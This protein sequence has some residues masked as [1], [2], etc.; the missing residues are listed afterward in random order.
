MAVAMMLIVTTFGTANADIEVD[1]ITLV[2]LSSLPEQFPSDIRLS[3]NGRYVTLNVSNGVRDYV[4]IDLDT[5]VITDVAL[6]RTVPSEDGATVTGAVLGGDGTLM[7]E[8]LATGELEPAREA[9]DV[10]DGLQIDGFRLRVASAIDGFLLVSATTEDGS[11]SDT[12]LW[13][14]VRGEIAT[15][16]TFLPRD[17]NLVTGAQ[18]STL[19]GREVLQY[20]TYGVVGAIFSTREVIDLETLERTTI[21]MPAEH[22]PFL[23]TW[24]LSSNHEWIVFISEQ[25]DVV[26]GLDDTPRYYRLHR[27]SGDVEALPIDATGSDRSRIVILD[28]GKVIFDGPAPDR[29]T[30][31]LY[32]W[33]GGDSAEQLLRSVNGGTADQGLGSWVP[34]WQVTPSGRSIVFTSWASDLVAETGPEEFVLRLYRIGES[35]PVAPALVV[36]GAAASS[37][38]R[39]AVRCGSDGCTS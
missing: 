15:E 4:H 27:P 23:G 38:L 19:N 2:D 29:V 9:I 34:S 35:D 12:I 1:P 30:T 16:S 6:D 11:S 14:A 3:E 17:A 13:D 39:A 31:F 24:T 18:F 26:P 10:P 20:W 25:A 7:R 33:S 37:S 8:S 32:S 22:A 36:E 5:G 28:S 21:E